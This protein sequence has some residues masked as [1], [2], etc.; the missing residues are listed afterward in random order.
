MKELESALSFIDSEINYHTEKLLELDAKLKAL[1]FK[2]H[3]LSVE[4][5]SS[6]LAEESK[7]IGER[8]KEVGLAIENLERE[9]NIVNSKIE[10]LWKSKM[11][12]NGIMENYTPNAP[13]TPEDHAAPKK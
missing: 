11:N 12:V 5:A 7:A 1:T 3:D 9:I 8:S 6:N 13:V 4:Y 2:A 10:G